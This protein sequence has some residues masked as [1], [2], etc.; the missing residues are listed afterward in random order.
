[1]ATSIRKKKVRI[2]FIHL[3]RFIGGKSNFKNKQGFLKF[4]KI[5]TGEFLC[6]GCVDPPEI[7]HR[8]FQG[9]FPLYIPTELRFFSGATGRKSF[10]GD[11]EGMTLKKT[12]TTGGWASVYALSVNVRIIPVP[13]SGIGQGGLHLP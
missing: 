1:V 9:C 7:P 5:G 6:S 4:T 11:R 8:T 10:I 2:D 12:S 3:W 13:G